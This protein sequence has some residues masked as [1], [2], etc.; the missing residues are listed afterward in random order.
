MKEKPGKSLF[1]T[2]L[3]NIFSLRG[4]KEDRDAEPL[5]IDL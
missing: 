3:K 1:V 5:N 2:I 4:R